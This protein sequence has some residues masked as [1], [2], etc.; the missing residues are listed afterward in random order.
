MGQNWTLTYKHQNI[1]VFT[2]WIRGRFKITN[3]FAFCSSRCLRIR[4]SSVIEKQCYA[5]IFT[6]RRYYAQRRQRGMPSSCVCLCVCVSVTLRYCIKTAKRRIMQIMPHDSPGTLVFWHQSS[7][8]HSNGITT[9][10][11]GDKCAG[12]VDTAGRTTGHQK[13]PNFNS[14]EEIHERI[15]IVNLELNANLTSV[16]CSY[17]NAGLQIM[18]CLIPPFVYHQ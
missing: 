12:G 6:A 4:G 14:Y 15:E 9:R 18:Y 11:G 16:G 7:R 1:R 17:V 2:T 3:Q 8:R 5:V 10:Y 13:S